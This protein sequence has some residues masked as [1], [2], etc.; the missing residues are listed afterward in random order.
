MPQG[1]PQ[2]AWQRTSGASAVDNTSLTSVGGAATQAIVA[3]IDASQGRC[4]VERS[5]CHAHAGC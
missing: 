5:I 2:G 4:G 1:G 3:Y